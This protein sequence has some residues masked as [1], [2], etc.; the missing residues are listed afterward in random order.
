MMMIMTDDDDDDD[1]DDDDDDDNDD[2]LT[3][4]MRPAVSAF[5]ADSGKVIWPDL[6]QQR[7]AA[8]WVRGIDGPTRHVPTHV[9]THGQRRQRLYSYGPYSGR[10]I[11]GRTRYVST[12]AYTHGLH[13]RSTHVSTHMSTHMPKRVS[14]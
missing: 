9:C 11:D 5:P 14:K 12:H 2:D 8:S 10:G 4:M 7:P 1:G 3:M 6:R 13:G